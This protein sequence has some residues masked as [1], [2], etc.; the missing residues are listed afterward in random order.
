MKKRLLVPVL[1]LAMMFCAV[2]ISVS[3]AGSD[4]KLTFEVETKTVTIEEAAGEIEVRIKLKNA[5]VLNLANINLRVDSGL[6]L[7]DGK[8]IPD[9]TG[10]IIVTDPG[11]S[12]HPKGKRI[13]WIGWILSD[14][15]IQFVKLKFVV[16]D[17]SKVGNYPIA[18]SVED[19]YSQKSGRIGDFNEIPGGI[20]VVCYHSSKTETPAKSASCTSPGNNKYYTCNSC[21]K[22][23]KADGVTETTV[24]AE[25]I[26]LLEHKYEE[27]WTA[28]GKSGHFHACSGCGGHDQV[29]PHEDS[30]DDGICDTCKYI[31][32][33]KVLE[34]A[35]STMNLNSGDDLT[36]RANGDYSD[37]TGVLVDGL[38]VDP[39][40][41]DSWEGSTYVRLYADYLDTL[42]AG[43][44]TVTIQFTNSSASTD[45]TL[46]AAAAKPSGDDSA[47]GDASAKDAASVKTGDSADMLLWI[48]LLI[49]SGV[50][51]AVLT[52]FGRKKWCISKRK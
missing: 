38:L 1:I 48:S 4:D 10:T 15:E 49:V 50:G 36:L 40:Y 19:A 21:G 26:G 11:A 6:T 14:D 2:P 52:A 35:G 45:F 9:H 3:A 33:Y 20:N 23:F 31:M 5:K 25:T 16:N 47:K 32:E 46:L 41:Y 13:G 27:A 34:G 44:H 8:F 17:K 37:F 28:G 22:V 29:V 24:E 12:I 43:K 51:I 30:D 39:E 18:V 7:I 42:D